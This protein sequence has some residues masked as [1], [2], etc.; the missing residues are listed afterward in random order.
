MDEQ[1]LSQVQFKLVGALR[2]Y[3][4]A[5]AAL[6]RAFAA[7]LSLH[8]TDAA[9]LAEIFFAEDVS[10]PL[11]PTGLAERIGRSKPATS[12]VLSRL[13]EAGLVKRLR[14]DTD[15]RVSVLLA[16]E[17]VDAAIPSFFQPLSD[18]MAAH[19]SLQKPEQ[20][21]ALISLL[22][23]TTDCVLAEIPG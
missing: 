3:G 18:A 9:A 11:T 17:K 5:H 19:L 14:H 1:L 12:A 10:Q 23:A 4:A 15:R 20:L 13:E 6:M 16:G 21:E 2:R 7:N 22:E 8:P